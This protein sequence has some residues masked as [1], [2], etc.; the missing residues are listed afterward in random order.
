MT[1]A[2]AQNRLPG[3]ASC[4]VPHAIRLRRDI[5]KKLGLLVTA[6]KQ[7]ADDHHGDAP[8]VRRCSTGE[9]VECGR[10]IPDVLI[11]TC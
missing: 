9:R 2:S 4:G 8:C 1:R 6:L 5:G 11:P 10:F 3:F 7:F